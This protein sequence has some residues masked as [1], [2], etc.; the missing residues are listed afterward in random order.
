MNDTD[1]T[2]AGLDAYW[3]AVERV[4]WRTIEAARNPL[5]ADLLDSIHDRT[6]VLTRRLVVLP[7]R[8]EQCIT[9][10]HAILAAMR[11]GD[12][13]EAEALRRANIRSA[14]D[15]LQRYESFIF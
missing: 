13:A 1:M 6:K 3:N 8:A 15:W 5:L 11:R 14:R 2:E 7:G 12:A 4:R 10:Q 9:E